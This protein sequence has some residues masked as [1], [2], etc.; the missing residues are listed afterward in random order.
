MSNVLGTS[1]Q[2]QCLDRR[3]FGDKSGRT[4][5]FRAFMITIFDN[6]YLTMFRV[7]EEGL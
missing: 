3:K 2:T 4:N 5:P 7:A 1:S 6:V